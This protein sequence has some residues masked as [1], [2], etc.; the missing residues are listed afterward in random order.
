M[1]TN[2]QNSKNTN[3]NQLVNRLKEKDS[4]YATFSKAL[5]IMYF[6]LIPLYTLTTIWDYLDEKNKDE[7][8]GG[9]L[10]LISFI[11][12]IIIL[13]NY[14]KKYRNIDYSLPTISMLREAANRYKPFQWK[15]VWSIIAIIIMDIGLIFD[16]KD[17]FPI[18]FSQ[19]V[20][21]GIVIPGIIIGLII[22]Y[23][24]YKPVRDEA[25]KMIKEIEGE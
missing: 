9:G 22:W 12:F 18:F 5:R 15:S 7:L 25:L 3:L 16:W 13:T 20:F 8:I 2:N 6:I 11:I 14:Y 4:N 23:K 17:E 10:F 1:E 24:R 19:A 21:F